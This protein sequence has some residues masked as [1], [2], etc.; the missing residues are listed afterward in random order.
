MFL[1]VVFLFISYCLYK[2][3]GEQLLAKL[4]EH[5]LVFNDFIYTRPGVQIINF[6]LFKK[7]TLSKFFNLLTLTGVLTL[8]KFVI[9]PFY[10]QG[11]FREVLCGCPMIH[12]VSFVPTINSEVQNDIRS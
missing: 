1:S 9:S 10:Y 5:C 7:K 2:Q 3:F 12:Y 8:N 6:N 11:K 4:Y